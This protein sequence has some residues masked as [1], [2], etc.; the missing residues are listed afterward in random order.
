MLTILQI[1]V[2]QVLSFG[3]AHRSSSSIFQRY[4]WILKPYIMEVPIGPQALYFGGTHGSS[5]PIF[6]RY[7][8]VLKPYI[9][10]VPM[11][12]QALYFKG[13]PRCSS[14]ILSRYP[15][16]FKPSILGVLTALQVYIPE[17]LSL[18]PEVVY[19]GD[20]IGRRIL[21]LRETVKKPF[22]LAKLFQSPIPSRFSNFCVSSRPASFCYMNI[23]LL[24]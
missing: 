18:D 6:Q 2:S 22:R 16:V 13:T 19:S 14:T 21:E 7:P 17:R 12:P 4:P 1:N 20:P 8:Q 15:Q 23:T 10:E 5:G 9:L 11:G 24:S 3:G